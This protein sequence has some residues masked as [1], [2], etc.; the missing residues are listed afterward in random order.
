MT[1][2]PSAFSP[3]DFLALSD[4]LS[5]STDQAELRTALSRAYY[6][7]FLKA[8]ALLDMDRLQTSDVHGRVMRVLGLKSRRDSADLERLRR[9]RNRADYD[10][11]VLFAAL[12]VQREVGRARRLFERL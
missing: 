8:R 11:R 7:S 4:R 9:A 2:Q 6:A 10:I 12:D 5:R 1:S 3:E